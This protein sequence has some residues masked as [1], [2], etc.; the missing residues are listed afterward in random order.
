ME[1]RVTPKALSAV[2]GLAC[3]S[4]GGG[5]SKEVKSGVEVV[6]E[7]RRFSSSLISSTGPASGE[8]RRGFEAA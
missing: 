5:V 7:G 8:E 3:L 4:R 1:N 6:R 2:L